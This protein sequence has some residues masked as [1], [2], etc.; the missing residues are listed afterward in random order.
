M[1]GG[2]HGRLLRV[3]LSAGTADTLSLDEQLVED[4]IGGKGFGARF[5]YDLAEPECEAFDPSNPLMFMPG[6]LTGT[7]APSMREA[8]V[9]KS[10]L[11]DIYGDS[12]HGG[13]LGPE[14]KYAGYDGI[15]VVG[16]AN[17]PAYLYIDDAKVE[18]RDAGSLWGRD[19]YETYEALYGE[20]GDRSFQIAC[21]GPAGESLVRFALIDCSPH[22][23]AGRCGGG[24][25]MG[26]KN[27]KAIAVRGTHKLEV[28][29]PERF[30][31]SINKAHEAIKR[32]PIYTYL[33]TLGDTRGHGHLVG[34]SEYAVIPTYNAQRASFDQAG[35]IDGPLHRDHIWLRNTACMG[36]VMACSKIGVLRRG[37]HKGTVCD[38]V[39]YESAALMGANLGIG[40]LE[41]L[42]YACH[43]CD[44]YGLDTMSAGGVIGFAMEAAERGDLP[45]ADLGQLNLSFGNHK[46]VHQVLGMIA[47]REGIG[48]LLAEGVRRFAQSI[49]G[50]CWK[51]AMHIKGLEMAGYEPRGL[52]GMALGYMTGDKGGEHVQGYM[53]TWELGGYPWNGQAVDRFALKGKA[54]IL[55]WLQDYQVGTNTLVKCDFVKGLHDERGGPAATG[56]SPATFAEMLG[57]VTGRTVTPDDINLV[58]ERVT[59]LVRLFNLREGL[60]R[61]DDDLPYRCREEGLP[62]P[63]V[64]GHRLSREDL[65]YMLDDYYR[66]RGWD[67]AGVPTPTKL[68]ELGLSKEGRELGITSHQGPGAMQG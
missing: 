66:L 4:Y 41:G 6:P 17:A 65:D 48:N 26:S 15:I 57:T 46:V 44:L 10:P 32:W 50:D 40:D 34:H 9:F 53:P 60:T 39:E 30:L 62:D 16:R 2:Y 12:F 52:P 64:E 22:R 56:P 55:V 42:A 49:G 38:N 54:E 47:R 36:C 61:K 28:A 27:L 67:A 21:I 19:T 3:D 29:D 45:Q 11:T 31:E 5:L 51:Y 8:I 43:L 58:G 68:A 33:G 14:I 35:R 24:A 18:V 25:V 37:P 13:F 1:R 59:N 63:P 23:Q 20:L 7:L